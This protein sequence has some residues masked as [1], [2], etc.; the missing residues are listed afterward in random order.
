MAEDL[1]YRSLFLCDV[2]KRHNIPKESSILEIGCGDNRNLTFLQAHGYNLIVGIDKKYGSAIEDI[3]PI[4]YDVIF[5]M[6]TL[7]L[8]P[9]EN[10]WVF[11]KIAK[12][13]KKWII[14]I[15]GETTAGNGVIGRDY[16]EIFSKFGFKQVEH[17]EDVFNKY[18][19]LR[20]FKRND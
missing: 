13:A 10:E 1:N 18:G 14:T 4:E 3:Q 8:I 20:V 6:S 11:E 7:F 19:V 17:Q 15:E 5:T 9:V 2:F 16:N 12:M